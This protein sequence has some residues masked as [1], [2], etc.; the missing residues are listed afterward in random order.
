MTCCFSRIAFYRCKQLELRFAKLHRR[1]DKT[2]LTKT[3]RY[4][5][6]LVTKATS[7]AY[8]RA[9]LQNRKRHTIP[10]ALKQPCPR[11]MQLL[12]SHSLFLQ[13]HTGWAEGESEVDEENVLDMA[14][15]AL[16]STRVTFYDLDC[17]D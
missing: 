10:I 9:A 11:L 14:K 16:Y 17:C 4:A 13:A 15:R 12:Q 3:M 8:A 2:Q 5:F 7:A 1:N 6:V